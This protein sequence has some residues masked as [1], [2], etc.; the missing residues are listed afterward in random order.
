MDDRTTYD[1]CVKELSIDVVDFR[2]SSK[3]CMPFSSYL[4]CGKIFCIL[5]GSVRGRCSILRALSG[6]SLHPDF[7]LSGSIFYSGISSVNVS[8]MAQQ[9]QLL[10]FLTLRET[11]LFAARMK[12]LSSDI[13]DDKM[14]SD[15][16]MGAAQMPQRDFCETTVDDIIS[17]F[18]LQD[19]ANIS[20]GWDLAADSVDRHQLV[21][22]FVQRRLLSIAVHV[23][24]DPE[25]MLSIDIGI[26]GII[27][28]AKFR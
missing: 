27:L 21:L 10:P 11:L 17:Y 3:W 1:L 9:Y 26:F 18:N 4:S 20:V 25:G 23:L 16:G 19:C 2:S 7:L 5:G 6:R 22:S 15:F 13:E 8:Y 24:H 14:R 28:K 12:G